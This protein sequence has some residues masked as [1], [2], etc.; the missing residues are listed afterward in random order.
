MVLENT[1]KL[2]LERQ[3]TL[4]RA[5]AAALSFVAL[6]E[7]SGSGVHRAPFLFLSI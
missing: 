2:Y 7:T 1:E 5:V 6:L 3:V 4:A